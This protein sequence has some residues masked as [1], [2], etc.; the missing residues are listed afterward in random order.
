LLHQGVDIDS[1]SRDGRKPL[2]T[3]VLG[4]VT[5]VQEYLNHGTKVNTADIEGNTTLHE[6]AYKGHADVV[7]DL[8]NNGAGVEF[9]DE[10]VST[11]LHEEVYKGHVEVVREL[12]N[13]DVS[14]DF[15]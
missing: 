1:A 6:A 14:V 10:N 9:A 2:N 13:H 3:A 15:G 7:P 11:P 5:I 8:L 4:H 12:L